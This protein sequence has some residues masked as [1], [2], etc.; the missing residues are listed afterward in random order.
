MA[1]TV[2]VGA[3]KTASTHLQQSL[4]ALAPPMRGAGIHYLD[5]RHLRRWGHRLDDSLGEGAPAE[6]LRAVWQRHLD[7]AAE[8][9]PQI[10]L[11]EENILGSIRREALMGAAGIYPHAAARV[12]RLCAM[13]RRQP[14]E[15]FL[16]VREPLAFLTS[17]FSMQLE[18]GLARDFGAYVGDFDP[19]G[20]SW[21]GLAERLLA[22]DGVARLVVWR[23]EDYRALRPALLRRLLPAALAGRA[24]DPRPAVVGLSQAA[25]DAIRR[26]LAADPGAD[27]ATLAREAKAMFPRSAYP[28]RLQPL[29]AAAARRVRAAYGADIAR[30]GRLDRVMLLQPGGDG[31]L[32]EG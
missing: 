16:A 10:L 17:A 29:D 8:T 3:H 13:L 9:W 19:A 31:A 26:S 24:P 22:V 6:R 4:R 11:S 28:G 15:L 12:D 25:H 32:R 21:T 23:Y 18:G 14:V 1:V 2:H 27:L 5:V 30:L 7:A 20:L